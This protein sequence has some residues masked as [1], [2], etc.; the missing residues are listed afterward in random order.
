MAE[1]GTSV[2]DISV[3]SSRQYGASAA[4]LPLIVQANW[5]VRAVVLAA[6]AAVNVTTWTGAVVAAA[7]ALSGLVGLEHVIARVVPD[8]EQARRLHLER[9]RG[10]RGQRLARGALGEDDLHVV[11][12]AADVRGERDVAAGAVDVVLRA[13]LLVEAQRDLAAAAGGGHDRGGRSG[14]RE[15]V[16]LLVGGEEVDREA[17]EALVRAGRVLA[18][19]ADRDGGRV[20][21]DHVALGQVGAEGVAGHGDR[22]ARDDVRAVIDQAGRSVESSPSASSA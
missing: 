17:V 15:A 3:R 10:A 6:G 8:V 5:A 4:S 13:A 11:A 12:G 2:A 16:D 18:E 22:G 19:D 20:G 21:P 14:P 1:H 9:V 7:G